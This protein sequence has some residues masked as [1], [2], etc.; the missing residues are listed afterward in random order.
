MGNDRGRNVKRNKLTPGDNVGIKRN[1]RPHD[2]RMLQDNVNTLGLLDGV[3]SDLLDRDLE[4]VEP[5][6]RVGHGGRRER[7]AIRGEELADGIAVWRVALGQ[8]GTLCSRG[9]RRGRKSDVHDVPVHAEIVRQRRFRNRVRRS[10]TGRRGI[11]EVEEGD[12]VDARDVQVELGR[13]SGRVL[14]VE[15]EEPL[16]VLRVVLRPRRAHEPADRE[17]RREGEEDEQAGGEG[18][19]PTVAERQELPTRTVQPAAIL[20]CPAMGATQTHHRKSHQAESADEDRN[21]KVDGRVGT[22]ASR[23]RNE[24]VEEA[25]HAFDSNEQRQR[26]LV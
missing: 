23:E 11:D 18:G 19:A 14:H 9:N 20:V 7:D 1:H 6:G 12:A 2:A 17:D 15:D 5:R 26:L 16:R 25:D 21:D 24:Q 22:H 10:E 3:E 8:R 4:G 13:R